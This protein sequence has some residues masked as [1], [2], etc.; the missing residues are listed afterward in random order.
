MPKGSPRSEATKAKIAKGRTG[1]KHSEAT[2]E[3]ISRAN[4]LPIP[5]DFLANGHL[6][7]TKL[8][9]HYGV[10]VKTIYKWK[11]IKKIEAQKRPKASS[12]EAEKSWP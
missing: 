5:A 3:K 4:R 1:K 9:Q 10:S 8:A 11:A 7:Y 6:H 12:D 2:I